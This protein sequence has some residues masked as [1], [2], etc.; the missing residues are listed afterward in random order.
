MLEKL[1]GQ[2]THSSAFHCMNGEAEALMGKLT[3]PS[4]MG[5]CVWFS[6]LSPG[7]CP[8]PVLPA[9]CQC[10]PAGCSSTLR[11]LWVSF[12]K[13]PLQAPSSPLP[14]PL[15]PLHSP[16]QALC[17]LRWAPVLSSL[18]STPWPWCPGHVF[19]LDFTERQNPRTMVET[20]DD[21]VL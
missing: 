8:A 2:G 5:S 10:W 11:V 16:A 6:S 17:L 12:A 1:T 13:C 9:K 20:L 3:C 4:K 19:A 14:S 18:S 21:F 15:Y 7:S